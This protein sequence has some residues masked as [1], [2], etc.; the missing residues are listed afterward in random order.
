MVLSLPCHN[1]LIAVAYQ[2]KRM[3]RNAAPAAYGKHTRPL[4]TLQ[5]P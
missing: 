2:G 4:D 5:M 1:L 3:V